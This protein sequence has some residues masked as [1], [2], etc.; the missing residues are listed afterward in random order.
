M[1]LLHPYFLFPS[2]SRC[3]VDITDLKRDV[4][5]DMW[6]PLIGVNG[7]DSSGS[8]HFTLVITGTPVTEETECHS[9]MEKSYVCHLINLITCN[10]IV[11]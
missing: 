6:L 7:L 2:L 1:Y 10:S 11:S 5:H 9:N 4:T 3:S 8:I